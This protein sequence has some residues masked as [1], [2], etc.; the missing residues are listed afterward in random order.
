MLAK[1][2]NQIKAFNTTGEMPLYEKMHITT[3]K[4]VNF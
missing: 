2:S 3:N 4:A 1:M